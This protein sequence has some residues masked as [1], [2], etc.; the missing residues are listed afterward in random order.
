MTKLSP[1]QIAEAAKT[2]GFT[3]NDL[4]TA[5]AVALAESG[6]DPNAHNAVPPDN[7]YG[8]WQINM[9]GDLG[10]TRRKWFGIKLN[11]QLFGPTR[12]ADAAYKIFKQSGWKAWTTYTSGKYKMYL[13]EAKNAA[14]NPDSGYTFGEYAGDKV[15][16]VKDSIT[17]P[18]TSVAG[19][20][21]NG[22]N[23]IV[24]IVLAIALFVVG[25]LLLARNTTAVKAGSKAVKL[26]VLKKV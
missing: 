21:T 20:L 13:G 6:G 17:S 8:L 19:A 4:V 1:P 14:A 16:E 3:G 24:G 5:V 11:D 18:L 15:D 26:A 2:A 12:N 25:V 7:S 10:P 23:S 22:V 9:I